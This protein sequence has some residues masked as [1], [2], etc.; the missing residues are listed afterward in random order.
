MRIAAFVRSQVDDGTL[1]PGDTVCITTVA[2][3][4]GV[5]RDTAAEG[6]SLLEA[7]GRLKRHPSHGYTVTDAGC[8]QPASPQA[9]PARSGRAPGPPY[10]RIIAAA[11]R[12]RV[13][14][15]TLKPG[16]KVYIAALTSEY[17]VSV[18]L[19][20]G[21]LHLLEAEGF[22]KGFPGYG[23]VVQGT[24]SRQGAAAGAGAPR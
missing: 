10:V 13:D 7:E 9:P 22:L 4:H 18:G 16:D 24:A 5:S 1:K 8:T 20:A 17:G 3:R 11:I 14:D 19:V 21:A 6:L 23:Y 15:G 2:Q 12:A